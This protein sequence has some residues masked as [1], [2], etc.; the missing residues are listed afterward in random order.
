[1]DRDNRWDRVKRAYDAMVR[2]EGKYFEDPVQGINGATQT[3]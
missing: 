1:M 2:G 3:V